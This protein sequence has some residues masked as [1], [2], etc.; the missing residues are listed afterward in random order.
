MKEYKKL[1]LSNKAW[2]S[3]KL[4]VDEHYFD[5]LSKDQKPLFL[6]IGCA[7]S[8]VPAEEITHA[9]PGDIFVHRNVANMVVHTDMNLLSVL[10]YAVEVLQ[11]KHVIVCGHYNCGGVRAAMTNKDYGLINKWLRNI[12]EVY[13][14]NFEEIHALPSEKDQ[15]DRLVE[16]NVKEQVLNL[17]K[18]TIIQKAWKKF[19]YPYLHGWVFDMHHGEIKEILNIDPNEWQSSVFSFNFDEEL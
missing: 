15:F 6:W 2:A 8:R 19:E 14:K 13:E 11:V 17:A 12:K 1:L 7:D 9:N 5:D 4:A 3:E 18:T 10:Q 16:L